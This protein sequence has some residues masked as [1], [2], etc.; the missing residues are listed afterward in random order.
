MCHF[1][2]LLMQAA[3]IESLAFLHGILFVMAGR[4]M[5]EGLR[6]WLGEYLASILLIVPQER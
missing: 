5:I 6:D 2:W 4:K 1:K 3:V